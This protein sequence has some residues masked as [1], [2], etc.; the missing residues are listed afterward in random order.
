VLFSELDERRGAMASR[1]VVPIAE[2]W[3]PVGWVLVWGRDVKQTSTPVTMAPVD[4]VPTLLYLTGHRVSNDQDGIVRFELF[5]D[6][7]YHMKRVH[8]ADAS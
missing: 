5:Q 1:D 6:Q 8:Y 7:L 4:L 3:P 2:S